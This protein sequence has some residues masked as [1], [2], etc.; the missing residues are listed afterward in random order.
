MSFDPEYVS[1]ETESFRVENL[2][3]F[4]KEGST[5]PLKY[6]DMYIKGFGLNPISYTEKGMPQ[7]DSNVIRELA[8]K[9]PE[10]G[11]Y[12]LAYEQMVTKGREEDGIQMSI[13]LDSWLRFKHIE[14]LLSTYIKPLQL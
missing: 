13:A 8:G 11:Q 14:K 12:G 5:K 10:K 9:D 3:G 1:Q 2:S 6:R 4:I 7:A